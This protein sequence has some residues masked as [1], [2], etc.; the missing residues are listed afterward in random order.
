M[1]RA[2][3]YD[4]WRT[5]ASEEYSI[6]GGNI[7]QARRK[8]WFRARRYGFDIATALIILQLCFLLWKWA[9]EAGY[10]Q[11]VSPYV[12]EGEPDFVELRKDPAVMRSLN[13]WTVSSFGFSVDSVDEGLA[14]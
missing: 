13:D 9:K 14:S 4:Q 5:W 11:T 3:N 2:T 8:M 10:L 6:A 12:Y 7:R 1:S